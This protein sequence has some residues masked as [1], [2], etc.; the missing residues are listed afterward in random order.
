MVLDVALDVC[1][2]FG[3]CCFRY[4]LLLVFVMLLMMVLSVVDSFGC[5]LVFLGWVFCWRFSFGFVVGSYSCLLVVLGICWWFGC[6][7]GLLVRGGF[8]SMLV[9]LGVACLLL[10]GFLSFF[11]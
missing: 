5:L 7:F 1:C 11:G 4:C 9:F 10:L 8:S 6:W 3:C 2:G